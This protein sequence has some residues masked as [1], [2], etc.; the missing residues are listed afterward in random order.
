MGDSCRNALKCE[1]AIKR[2]FSEST[3]SQR[4]YKISHNEEV[5]KL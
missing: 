5:R 3:R 1:L 2:G 4:G